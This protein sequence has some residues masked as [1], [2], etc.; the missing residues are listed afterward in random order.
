VKNNAVTVLEVLVVVIII[1]ILSAIAIPIYT[2]KIE[3]TRGE[4]AIANIEMIVDAWKIYR[5]KTG[6]PYYCSSDD[7]S[8]HSN[9][10][11]LNANNIANINTYLNLEIH[12]D[13]FSYNIHREYGTGAEHIYFFA[14]RTSKNK[15]LIYGIGNLIYGDYYQFHGEGWYFLCEELTW[16]WQPKTPAWPPAWPS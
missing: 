1:G 13:N 2:N 11:Y 6:Q 3:R 16:P 5:V 4:R 8:S 14:S 10:A 12:D 15:F 7:L 9:P